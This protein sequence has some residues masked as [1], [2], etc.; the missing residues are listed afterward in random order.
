MEASE[1][2]ENICLENING[3]GSLYFPKDSS[4]GFDFSRLYN[5]KV[6]NPSKCIKCLCDKYV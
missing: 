6:I 4:E 2:R 5:K 3:Y 1:V